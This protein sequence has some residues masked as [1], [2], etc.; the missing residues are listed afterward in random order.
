[1]ATKTK[2]YGYYWK[3][4][5]LALVEQETTAYPLEGYPEGRTQWTSPTATVADALEIEY[6]Y[7]PEYT[8][9]DIEDKSTAITGYD[10]AL[11]LLKFTGSGLSTDAAI[12]HIVI[13]GSKKWNGLHKIN[14]LNVN[15]WIVETI[16]NGAAVV[17]N[18]TAYTDINVL[19]SADDE[20][21]LTPY[22][23]K[24][25]IYY[26]KAKVFEDMMDIERKEYFMREFR[27]TLEKHE[28]S[29]VYGARILSSGPNAIR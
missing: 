14:T 6:C 20:I 29:K 17:E 3:G 12:T 11:G 21:P 25:L 15:Y 22:L 27:R 13:K 8:I 7:S 28:N 4:N 9:N 16:Y 18:P 1:M 26:I 10:E 19:N 23:E 24:A 5:K 2:A